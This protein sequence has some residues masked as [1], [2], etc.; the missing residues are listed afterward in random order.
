LYNVFLRFK[1]WHSTIEGVNGCF[2]VSAAV[3]QDQPKIMKKQ[4][5]CFELDSQYNIEPTLSKCAPDS[6]SKPGKRAKIKAIM[7]GR[8]AAIRKS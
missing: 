5:S 7:P 3:N 6:S 8:S 2:L 4:E 1:G